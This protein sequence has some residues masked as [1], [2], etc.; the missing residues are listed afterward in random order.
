MWFSVLKL[1]QST[2]T[3]A[4]NNSTSNPASK[5][6]KNGDQNKP[7]CKPVE[8]N[9]CHRKFK[10][11]PALNGHMRLHGGYFKKVRLFSLSHSISFSVW[12]YLI[13]STIPKCA[14]QGWG[15][16][17]LEREVLYN[18]Y[19]TARQKTRRI[20]PPCYRTNEVRSWKNDVKISRYTRLMI[21]FRETIVRMKLRG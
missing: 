6:G 1:F 14:G 2:N 7:E 5:D 20:F 19:Y 10:N 3:S 11:V 9:L 17:R 18:C 13:K 21:Q 12:E 16:R 15:R 8:C 4:A